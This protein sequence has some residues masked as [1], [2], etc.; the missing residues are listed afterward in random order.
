MSSART[1]TPQS[2][3]LPQKNPTGAQT[4]IPAPFF[5]ITLLVA[6]VSASQQ[7]IAQIVADELW[8]IGIGAEVA[9][10]DS[11]TFT[12]RVYK[13]T[14]NTTH[15]AGGFDAAFVELEGTLLNPSSLR[16]TFHSEFIDKT[17]GGANFFPSDNITLDAYLD[18]MERTRAY[19]LRLEQVR[20]AL[21]EI[22]WG[23]SSL[24]E[25]QSGALASGIL[26]RTNPYALD[27]DVRGFDATRWTMNQPAIAEMSFGSG[28]D[29]FIFATT[30]GFMDLNP[31]MS[32]TP[33]DHLISRPVFSRLYEQDA[34]LLFYPV[35]ARKE[36][37]PIGSEE[38][39]VAH[40][41][42]GTISIDSPYFGATAATTW[43]ESPNIDS[44]SYDPI[45]T[46][47]N[48][49][50]FLIDLRKDIPWHPG[51][52]YTL[53]DFNVTA[54]DFIWTMSYMLNDT[55]YN[56]SL[57]SYEA[58]WGSNST[59]AIEKINE[60]MV[61]VNFRGLRGDGCVADWFDALSLTPL[62]RHILD[63]T[64]DATP[65]GG[66]PGISPD[67]TT[68]ASYPDQRSYRYN[69]GVGPG[70]SLVGCGPYYFVEWDEIVETAI[71]GKFS[72]WG[73]YG[74]NSLWQDPHFQNNNINTYAVA[75]YP[76]KESAELALENEEIDGID[77][78]FEIH[79]DIPNLR[80]KTNI[81][82]L[83][84]VSPNTESIGF[85]AY[86]PNLANRFVRLAIAHAIDRQSIIDQALN[87]TAGRTDTPAMPQVNPYYPSA[88]EWN[89]L[90]LPDLDMTGHIHYNLS[91]AWRL[92]E[93]AGYD[94]TWYKESFRPPDVSFLSPMEDA[95]L[96]G[97]QVLSINAT[98][99]V[100]LDHVALYID[101]VWQQNFTT[102][103]VSF[104]WNTSQWA[105][106]NHT[107]KA[108]A[109]SILGY[110]AQVTLDV[111]VDNT[112]PTILK[113]EVPPS[114]VKGLIT[115]NCTAN[116]TFGVSYAELFIGSLSSKDTTPTE[117]AQGELFQ[118]TLDTR[119]MPDGK[120]A[121]QLNVT[122]KAGNT[123]H[124]F[125]NVTILNSPTID[126]PADI[127]YT[128]RQTGNSIRWQPSDDDP[129]SYEILQNG[130]RVASGSW[131]GG[132]IEYNIDGLS[133][134]IYNFTL[135]VQD[136]A[137]NTAADSVLVTVK[138][139]SKDDDD[140]FIIPGMLAIS[141]L[142]ILWGAGIRVSRRRKTSE[143]RN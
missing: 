21:Q 2:S 128:Q 61:K 72:D 79:E 9:V 25:T 70:P 48:Y 54:D 101:D 28:Q 124:W 38:T 19:S 116:D 104:I 62:P 60:T 16:N 27:A 18:E 138:P 12:Q 123:N 53:K 71:L 36:P 85:N 113:V 43:G 69:T 119:S 133:P 107:L 3:Y 115:I 135:I 81:E 66:D 58:V 59:K 131:E 78:P 122:D 40:V 91:R 34:N 134:G 77:F 55:L 37:M 63:P 20:L 15:A 76:S 17:N 137:G 6:D 103:P 65:W 7:A 132:A 47:S 90:G 127:T 141:S 120:T 129:D 74:A 105:D 106:G 1:I 51:Y 73:G 26:Y 84:V 100:G 126:H 8:K 109:W 49:S 44:T 35:L 31:I 22:V 140:S 13:N 93:Q 46:A 114:P 83:L 110:S 82:V 99:N 118:F 87:G 29:I 117:T 98:A 80:A 143:S 52:G 92:M 23:S 95:F 50:M 139:S 39:I 67:A 42:L 32:Q 56:P 4:S 111:T 64:F 89:S 33:Y 136:K 121:V 14:G 5:N 94:V 112:A 142:L 108:V 97:S 30:S 130:T 45:V 41:D 10:V 24:T 125:G 11:N 86:H 57:A 102:I 68:I 88:N 96:R 75:I